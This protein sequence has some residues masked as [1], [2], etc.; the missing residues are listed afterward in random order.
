MKNFIKKCLGV[1]ALTVALNFAQ[2]GV[3]ASDCFDDCNPCDDA[4]ICNPCDDLIDC[5]K[6]TQRLISFWIEGGVTRNQFGRRDFYDDGLVP[7]NAYVLQN[8]K[9]TELVVNQLWISGERKV[10]RRGFDI[11]GRMDFVF[12]TD[13]KYLQSDGFELKSRDAE[14]Y[15]AFN[16]GDYGG[17]FAQAYGE[18]GYNRLNI[19]I[20]KMLSTLETEFDSVEAP[21]RNF[22]SW[23]YTH[24]VKPHTMTGI[25]ADYKLSNRL[26]AFGGWTTGFD[27]SFYNEKDN[28]VVGGVKANLGK[29]HVLYS[30][31]LG[32][33]KANENGK[34]EY[35]VQTLAASAKL[36]KK[37]TYNFDWTLRNDKVDGAYLGAYGI[38][39]ELIYKLN[40]KWSVGA[41]VEWMHVYDFP[42]AHSEELVNGDF[43]ALTFGAT[44]TP[45][46]WLLVRPEI[47]YDSISGGELTPFGK[48]IDKR[49]QTS[50]GI[51]AV[52]KF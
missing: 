43:T 1:A 4:S 3:Q 33:D 5:G 37:L 25:V 40:A 11:G 41:R 51:S 46:K 47:R 36:S 48:E 32:R 28:A 19:K 29:V 50:Y 39:Q 34:Y 18:I 30:A 14:G 16:N 38:N 22:Y 21:H 8:A 27:Q 10:S 20:G 45:A 7:G 17:A 49:Y 23:S 12:G 44:W 15:N 13:A 42:F 31:A 2:A 24:A 35:I 52:A 6:K 9:Q 26:T